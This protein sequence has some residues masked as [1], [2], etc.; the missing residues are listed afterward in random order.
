MRVWRDEGVMGEAGSV[1]KDLGEKQ[2][3]EDY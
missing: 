3:I 1:Q 2:E